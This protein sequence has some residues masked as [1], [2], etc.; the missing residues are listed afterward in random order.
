MK[1]PTLDNRYSLMGLMGCC[2]LKNLDKTENGDRNMRNFH[3][4]GS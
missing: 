1:H 2:F 3:E 4:K